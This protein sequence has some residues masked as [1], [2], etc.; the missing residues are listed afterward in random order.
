[1][2]GRFFSDSERCGRL[3]RVRGHSGRAVGDES[4]VRGDRKTGKEPGSVGA[5]AAAA[6]EGVTDTTWG[7]RSDGGRIENRD[8]GAGLWRKQIRRNRGRERGC[9]H[10]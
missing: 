8:D 5:G 4:R 10:E 7:C 9:D 3:L 1:K 6:V 2:G